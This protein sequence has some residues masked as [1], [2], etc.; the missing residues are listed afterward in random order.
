MY[1]SSFIPKRFIL[2]VVKNL[3]KNYR[4]Q[5]LS[6][7]AVTA[8]LENKYWLTFDRGRLASILVS[9]LAQDNSIYATTRKDT[10][11]KVYILLFFN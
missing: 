5:E 4:T 11:G 8:L 7:L 3:L 9:Q 1:L 6:L 2:K 10:K